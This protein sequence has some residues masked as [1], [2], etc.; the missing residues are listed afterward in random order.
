MVPV[1]L[2]LRNFMCYRGSENQIDFTGVHLACLTGNN[3]QGK[4][5]LLDA[6]TWALWGKARTNSSDALISYGES[7]MDVQLEFDLSGSRYRVIRKRSSAGRGSS[8]LELQGQ[9]RKGF[10]ASL[11]EG[12]IRQTQHRINKLLRLDYETFVNSAFLLQGRADEFTTKRPNERKQI[13]TDILGLAQ[14]DEYAKRS[15]K[16]T[17]VAEKQRGQL[18]VELK[19]IKRIVAQIPTFEEQVVNAEA[20]ARVVGQQLRE[21][22]DLLQELFDQRRELNA[23]AEALTQAELQAKEARKK[24]AKVSSQLAQQHTKIQR[25]DALLARA[26]EIKVAIAELEQARADHA[27]WDDLLRQ[28]L[29]LQNEASGLQRVIDQARGVLQGDLRSVESQIRTNQRTLKR[30]SSREQELV[31]AQKQVELLEQLQK[32]RADKQRLLI[33]WKEASGQL[34]AE[35]LS[36]REAMQDLKERM[37]LLEGSDAPDCLVCRRPLS[38]EGRIEALE[39][40]QQEGK[41]MGDRY[42]ENKSEMARVAGE[43]KSLD[44]QI[45]SAD[46]Q[47]VELGRWQRRAA[48]AAQAAEEMRHIQEQLQQ[49][50]A[51]A[52]ALRAR[53][54][55]GDYARQEQ[56]RLAELASANESLAYDRAQHDAARATIQKLAPRQ[57]EF[58][59]L[60][61]AQEQR[62]NVLEMIHTLEENQTHWQERLGAIEEQIQTLTQELTQRAAV[63]RRVQEQQV[64]VNKLQRAKTIVERRHGAARQKLEDAEKHAAKQ[65][66]VEKAY[67]EAVTER[68]IYEQLSNAFGKR[69]VQAMIIESAIPDI[70]AEA[71]KL[72]SRMTNGRM[73]VSMLTQRELKS[74]STSETLDILI[75][76]EQGERPYETFSGGEAFRVNFALRIA[77]SK[78]LAH[79]AGTNLRTLVM[80]EGFG[81]QDAQGRERLIEAITSVQEDF[82]RIIVI[83]HI[84]ELKEAF[85]IRIEVV[86]G[87]LGSV[88]TIN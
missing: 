48:K 73:S 33:E 82:D 17:Q 29:E 62:T 64:K 84:E 81:S 5:A 9:T 14:Y 21:A 59:E 6:I 49:A 77:L 35:N 2:H 23:K 25:F 63:L 55:A 37:N 34:R 70:E 75:A 80:D 69:G 74:G 30:F 28:S 87:P 32:E 41:T 61:M 11:S 44:E 65:P 3:G 88:V 31:E 7:D 1:K 24:I 43:I 76:D 13:L 36:L 22:T 42:R 12:T 38:P 47:L 39:D 78:L 66:E 72:L 26:D 68:T 27:R 50:E 60:A 15:K 45:R 19:R 52:A 79:R 51:E 53:M 20:E 54:E 8:M 71:N 16:R 58:N 40:A 56:T 18:D 10:F 57:R 4:S 46:R 83:T 86:K 85:P 67:H